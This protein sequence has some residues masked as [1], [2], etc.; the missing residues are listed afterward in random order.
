MLHQAYFGS[1][2]GKLSF[3]ALAR[4]LRQSGKADFGCLDAFRTSVFVLQTGINKQI[5][6]WHVAQLCDLC[7]SSPLA[8][9][10]DGYGRDEGS[11]HISARH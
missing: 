3:A 5:V 10:L 6:S 2:G 4:Y 11:T 8:I 9:D 1:K 7:L